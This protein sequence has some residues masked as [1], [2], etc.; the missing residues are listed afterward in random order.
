MIINVLSINTNFGSG[1]VPRMSQWIRK[2][3]N[4]I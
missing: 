3:I 1:Y 2:I 4:D